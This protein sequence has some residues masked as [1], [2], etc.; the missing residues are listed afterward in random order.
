[1]TRLVLGYE[2]V[3]SYKR[4]SYTPWHALAEFV[5]NSTQA[6][7]NHKDELDR[8]FEDDEERLRVEIDYDS[9]NGRIRI[10]DNSIGM[11]SDL[12]DHAMTVGQAPANTS[13]RSR[14]GMGLKTAAF[15]LGDHWTLRSSRLGTP[16]QYT[17]TVDVDRVARGDA[18]LP[19]HEEA[20]EASAHFTI[21]EI[22][23]LNRTFRGRT[24]GKI[25]DYLASMYRS[26]LRSGQLELRWQGEPLRWEESDDRFLVGADGQPHRRNVDF[27]IGGKRVAG[28]AGV[29]ARGSRA[30]AGFSMLHSGRVVRGWPESWRPEEVFGQVEGSNDLVNQRLVGEFHLDDFDV[31][32]TKDDILWSS[33]EEDATG[34]AIR[35]AIAELID[36]ARTARVRTKAGPTRGSVKKA[37]GRLQ[38]GVTSAPPDEISVPPSAEES[39]E[40]GVGALVRKYSATAADVTGIIFGRQVQAYLSDEEG[41]EALFASVA[42]G[43]SQADALVVIA[44]MNHP[45]LKEVTSSEGLSVYLRD[46][47]LDIVSID[48]VWGLISAERWILR[49][50]AMM[51]DW[52]GS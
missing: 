29:L 51:R 28:W 8:Q 7:A 42:E 26:D 25:R 50:D 10:A 9:V 39:Y 19:M 31:T 32:H 14:Y 38:S 24:L 41:P 43:Q 22:T 44:N 48:D 13:G 33:A 18:D 30:Q 34:E 3:R 20:A 21:I 37:A 36:V 52:D 11:D 5:D 6:Y 35:E 46:M 27:S 16:V 2:V 45:F 40:E 12:I 49:K 15:W 1:M 23:R 17:V 47:L 4:L